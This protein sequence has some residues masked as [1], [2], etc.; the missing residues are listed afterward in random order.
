MPKL[1]IAGQEMRIGM[2]RTHAFMVFTPP[3]SK[4]L[5]L[6][7]DSPFHPSEENKTISFE[8]QKRQLFTFPRGSFGWND[9][10][11]ETAFQEAA[12]ALA[13]Q[14]EIDRFAVGSMELDSKEPIKELL[15]AEVTV[16]P[17][18]PAEEIAYTEQ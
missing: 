13:S 8:A 2:N 11:R 5:S 15:K 10:G 17:V 12:T 18:K 7:V 16:I 4:N 6:V 9:E 14:L 3:L 1:K